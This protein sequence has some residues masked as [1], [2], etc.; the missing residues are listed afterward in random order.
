MHQS[1][2]YV[3]NNETLSHQKINHPSCEG[4]A[5]PRDTVEPGQ[6][7]HLDWDVAGGLESCWYS[8][9][10]IGGLIVALTGLWAKD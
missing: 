5:R 7:K 3:L 4:S 9:L 6:A 2:S 1:I 10:T 8:A